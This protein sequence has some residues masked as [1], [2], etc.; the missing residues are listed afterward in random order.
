M[1]TVL[2]FLIYNS[3]F[4]ITEIFMKGEKQAFSEFFFQDSFQEFFFAQEKVTQGAGG[5]RHY[6]PIR[7]KEEKSGANISRR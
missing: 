7:G 4:I 2:L 1:R 5:S 3:L 6:T